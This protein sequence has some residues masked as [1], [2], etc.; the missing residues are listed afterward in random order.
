[1]EDRGIFLLN[2]ETLRRRE[3]TIYR[4]NGLYRS[5]S[6][7]SQIGVNGYTGR[8]GKENMWVL[9]AFRV[10]YLRVYCLKNLKTKVVL[11]PWTV[12]IQLVPSDSRM[13][14]FGVRV[15]VGK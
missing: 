1:M 9:F 14:M 10:I 11:K 3:W 12:P 15:R 5:V 8:D 6:L 7:V 13:R 2:M 4:R